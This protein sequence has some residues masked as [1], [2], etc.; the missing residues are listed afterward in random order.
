MNCRFIQLPGLDFYR[1]ESLFCIFFYLQHS[2][3]K[4]RLHFNIALLQFSSAQGVIMKKIIALAY[5]III[6]ISFLIC[7]E[8][9]PAE[10]E[11]KAEVKYGKVTL[12]EVLAA[13][14]EWRE[15]ADEYMPQSGAVEFLA[16][17]ALP[18]KI[19]IYY[20]HWCSDSV[21]NIPKFLKI[22]ELA[23]NPAFETEF[24]SVEKMK[25]GEKR[26]LV[27]NRQ[28]KAIP[29]FV[30]F[31]DGKEAGEIVENPTVSME[32]DLVTIINNII[33]PK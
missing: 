22:M 16:Q 32:E 3:F 28:L 11:K 31:L 29:T 33:E 8:R 15:K 24:W 2:L 5:F 1:N 7:Q 9:T 23:A 19:E 30:V 10:N 18:V 4:T 17:V 21:N 25:Q 14:P 26:G 20:G 13:S 12:A 6:G 27:N